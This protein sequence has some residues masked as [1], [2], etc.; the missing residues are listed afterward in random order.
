MHV[1]SVNV[2]R[3]QT[4]QWHGRPVLTSIWKSPV[5]GPVALV[6]DNLFGDEQSDLTVHGG[7]NKAVYAY[8]TEHYEYWRRELGVATL[9]WG[10]FGE[11]L[12]TVGLIETEVAIGDRFRI[13][14]AELVVTQPRLPCYKLGIRFGD[15]SMVKRFMAS[16]RSGIYFSIARP[17]RLQSGDAIERVA[18]VKDPI[19]IAQ[20]VALFAGDTDD[21]DLV[22]RAL[23]A[24]AL[25]AF[26]KEEFRALT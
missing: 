11:N 3:P 10:S 8:P 23:K 19:T 5:E 14:S 9:P 13:G 24:E 18:T 26:W 7:P 15:D 6:A 20:I 2:G 25:P 22:R 4:V 21:R 1:L 17:G 12:S 16:R